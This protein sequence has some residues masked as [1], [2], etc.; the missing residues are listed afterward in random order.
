MSELTPEPEQTKL[1]VIFFLKKKK[2][3]CKHFDFVVTKTIC[4]CND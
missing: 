3:I 4:Y 1:I 2:Q